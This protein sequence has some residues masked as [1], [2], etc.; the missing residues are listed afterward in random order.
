M[1]IP[2]WYPEAISIQDFIFWIKHFFVSEQ[3]VGENLFR[4]AGGIHWLL[5][6]IYTLISL[7]WADE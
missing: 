2:C 5:A 1:C 3:K 7:D 6:L 4:V